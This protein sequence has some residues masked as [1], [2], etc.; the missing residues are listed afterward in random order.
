MV[1]VGL[2]V[3]R[4]RRVLG[5]RILIGIRLIERER[6]E[7]VRPEDIAH[8]QQKDAPEANEHLSKALPHASSA[9][10]ADLKNKGENAQVGANKQT[11][12]RELLSDVSR[13]GF[14]RSMKDDVEKTPP[15]TVNGLR[16]VQ[17]ATLAS[18]FLGYHRCWLAAL[19]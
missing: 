2:L 7:I 13:D 12:Q 4:I 1:G 8:E 16:A 6:Y 17:A 14:H 15:N 5:A 9:F 11:P 18:T 10:G 3:T 19:G